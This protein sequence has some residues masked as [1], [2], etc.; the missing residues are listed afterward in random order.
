M[1]GFWFD[2]SD[3]HNGQYYRAANDIKF[4]IPEYGKY[5]PSLLWEYIPIAV[6][7][8]RKYLAK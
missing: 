4:H 8:N 7:V 5:F 6:K 3:S 2:F 1:T